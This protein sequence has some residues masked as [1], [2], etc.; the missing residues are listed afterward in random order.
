MKKMTPEERILA[1][2]LRMSA[3]LESQTKISRRYLY[4]RRK[5][6]ENVGKENPR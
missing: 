1:D 6:R 2:I 4:E 5:K 3:E